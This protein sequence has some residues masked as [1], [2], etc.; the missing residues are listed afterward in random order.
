MPNLEWILAEVQAVAGQYDT[1]LLLYGRA[2]QLQPNDI[3]ILN[4]A[5]R[6]AQIS[7]HETHC[8]HAPK[9][10]HFL[11]QLD[12]KGIEND[13]F[14]VRHIRCR[15]KSISLGRSWRWYHYWRYHCYIGLPIHENA[16]IIGKYAVDRWLRLVTRVDWS[17][18]NVTQFYLSCVA[19]HPSLMVLMVVV[20]AGVGYAL[21]RCYRYYVKQQR[22]GWLEPP[23]NLLDEFKKPTEA[24]AD[25]EAGESEQYVNRSRYTKAQARQRFKRG[26]T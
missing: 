14:P 6:I 10:S 8:K 25:G 3:S 22:I 21:A 13:C 4:A 20:M 24:D 12:Y 9:R 5:K 11:C 1:S 2:L 7:N 15:R 18:N 19:Q 23:V 26:R 17:I 16:F